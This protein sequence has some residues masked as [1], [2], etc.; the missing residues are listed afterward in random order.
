MNEERRH[1]VLVVEDDIGVREM[2]SAHLRRKGYEVVAVSSAEAVLEKIRGGDLDYDVA[3]TDVHLPGMSGVELNRLLLATSPLSPI[4]VI[5][6]DDNADLARRALQD[7]AAGYLL[8]PF[9]LFELDAALAQSVSMLQLVETT[10]ALARSQSRD[11]DDWGEL[12]G[13]LPR[14]WLHLGD[15]KS[16]AGRGHGARVVSVALLLAKQMGDAFSST[17]REVM[18]TAARTHE[19]GRLVGGGGPREVAKRSARLLSDLGF[20]E[21]VCELVRQSAEP[22]SPGLPLRA[23][24]LALADRLDHMA[25]LRAQEL[26]PDADPAAPV[27]GAVDAVLQGAGDTFDPEAARRLEASRERVESMWVLQRQVEV[28]V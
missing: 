17:D 10:E 15:E 25:V 7:G 4:I 3:L 27:Q 18:R 22:W 2:V 19:M 20:D 6:G 11:L 26:G 13:S 23:R 28:A 14:A 21:R 8:K 24:V 16:G 1:T 9:E 12:G 5:T